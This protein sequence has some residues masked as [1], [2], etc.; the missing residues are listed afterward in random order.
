MRT[1]YSLSGYDSDYI[2]GYLK[3]NGGYSAD[4][5]KR[6][7]PIVYDSYRLAVSENFAEADPVRNKADFD[8]TINFIL[9]KSGVERNFIEMFF[10]AIYAGIQ[11][12]IEK[13]DLLYIATKKEISALKTEEFIEKTGIKTIAKTAT[14]G[15]KTVAVVAGLGAAGFILFQIVNL[16]KLSKKVL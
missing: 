3:I 14:S 10:R 11:S 1:V 6:W 16:K 7:S 4:Q 5:I 2:T 13:P 15:F 9:S 12:G 8:K